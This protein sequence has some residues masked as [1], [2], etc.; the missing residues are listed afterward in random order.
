ML[1]SLECVT[2]LKPSDGEVWSICVNWK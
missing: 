1:S 2:L